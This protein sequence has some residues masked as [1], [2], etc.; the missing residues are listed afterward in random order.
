MKDK[1]DHKFAR[2]LATWLEQADRSLDTV[3]RQRLRQARESALRAQGEAESRPG[4]GWLVPAVAMASVLALVVTVLVSQTSKV[5]P[6]SET[7]VIEIIATSDSLELYQ[8][9]EFYQWL[10][11]QEASA[12]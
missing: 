8:D 12:G 2:D 3:T 4:R 11:E 5:L 1:P 9:I 7:D 10:A 6:G